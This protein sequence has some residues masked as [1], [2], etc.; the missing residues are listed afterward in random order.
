[1]ILQR[2]IRRRV[3]DASEQ[4][5]MLDFPQRVDQCEYDTENAIEASIG[6]ASQRSY[7]SPKRNREKPSKSVSLR[8]SAQEHAWLLTSSMTARTKAVC[9]P[10]KWG[11]LPQRVRHRCGFVHRRPRGLQQRPEQPQAYAG[12]TRTPL[13]SFLSKIRFSEEPRIHTQQIKTAV[14]LG[15]SSLRTEPRKGNKLATKQSPWIG[16]LPYPV[17]YLTLP[18]G[19]RCWAVPKTDQTGVSRSGGG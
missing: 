9:R 6:L 13:H 17:T 3:F 1:M 15:S 8:Q 2:I 10:G 12:S 18:K 5:G 16:G 19:G 4:H 7:D 11:H 14:P